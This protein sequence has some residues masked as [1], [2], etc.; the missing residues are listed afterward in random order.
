M[1]HFDP[2]LEPEVRKAR[3]HFI[4]QREKQL[5]SITVS[6]AESGV[7]FLFT[8]NAGGAIAVLTYLGAIASTTN[9]TQVLKYSL[10]M[11]FVGIILVGIYRAYLAETYGKMFKIF[12]KKTANYFTNEKEWEIYI[13]EIQEDVEILRKSQIARIFVYGSFVCFILGSTIGTFSL[14]I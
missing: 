3:E 11:F 6:A 4:D 1:H 13:S 10:A 14:F 2:E 5:Q 9:Q 12:Q 8:T 7:K